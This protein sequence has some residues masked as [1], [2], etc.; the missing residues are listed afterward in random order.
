MIRGYWFLYGPVIISILYYLISLIDF[1]LIIENWKQLDEHG[2]M[3][4]IYLLILICFTWILIFSPPICSYGSED[5]YKFTILQKMLMII[6]PLFIISNLLD[7]I[8]NIHKFLDKYLTI[9]LKK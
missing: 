7:L 3:D 9:K 2:K 8:L 4:F 1:S 6:N 5:W